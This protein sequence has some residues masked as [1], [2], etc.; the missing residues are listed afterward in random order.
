MRRRCSQLFFGHPRLGSRPAAACLARRPGVPFDG[1]PSAK[2]HAR[3][4]ATTSCSPHREVPDEHRGVGRTGRPDDS[5]RSPADPVAGVAGGQDARKLA[6]NVCVDG[7]RIDWGDGATPSIFHS[8]WLRHNCAK[9]RQEH[10]YF[11]VSAFSARTLMQAR[12]CSGQRV[13]PIT[14]ISD[15]ATVVRVESDE[16]EATLLVEWSDGHRSPYPITWLRAHAYDDRTLELTTRSRRC[17]PR[18]GFPH[19]NTRRL[20]TLSGYSRVPQGTLHVGGPSV[21]LLNQ[22]RRHVLGLWRTVTHDD[23]RRRRADFGVLSWC[24]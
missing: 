18:S 20:C 12:A 3:Q 9:Y 15:K 6:F 23:E 10:R 14:E 4:L 16:P 11:C 1:T 17:G 22:F 13:V 19:T 7:L 21:R 8:T 5:L 24:T 2:R